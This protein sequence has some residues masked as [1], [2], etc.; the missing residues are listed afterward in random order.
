MI[1]FF[2]FFFF[3]FFFLSSGDQENKRSRLE[4]P[5]APHLGPLPSHHPPNQGQNPPNGVSQGSVV[6]QQSAGFRGPLSI[7]NK[8]LPPEQQ[9]P[10]I[11]L[12]SVKNKEDVERVS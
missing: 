6:G 9:R 11:L 1:D 8:E 10:R 3:F 12:S 2:F 5:A 7:I 4:P